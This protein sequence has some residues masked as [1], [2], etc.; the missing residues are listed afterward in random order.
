[1]TLEAMREVADFYF[2]AFKKDLADLNIELPYSFPFASDHIHEDIDLVQT[3][4]DKGF[5]YATSDGI[6]FDISKFPAYGKLGNVNVSNEGESRI[7][8][9]SE[10]RNSRDFAVWKFFSDGDGNVQY[11]APFGKGRPGWHIECSAMSTWALG[12]TIDIHTGGTDLI[13]PHHTNEIA[14][15]ESAT[16]RHF[17]N[18]WLHSAYMNINDEKMSKS[19]KNFLKLADI[20]NEGISHSPLDIGF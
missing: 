12:S 13:F 10:K 7:G 8:L 15:S 19:K 16:D 18:Y 6:Y 14:Q 20:E 5:T 4:T 1:M 17:V 9:N 3:L 11:D 2:E